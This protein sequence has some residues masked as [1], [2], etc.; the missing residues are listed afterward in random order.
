MRNSEIILILTVMSIFI[1]SSAQATLAECPACKGEQPDW[2]ESAT[3]FLEGRPINDTPSSLNGPQQ[4]RLLDAQIDA[5]KKASQ[6]S[7]LTNNGAVPHNLTLNAFDIDLKEI[8]ARPNPAESN[9]AVR[10]VTVFENISSNSTIRYKPPKTPNLNPLIVYADI[11][12]SAGLDVGRVSLKPSSA[13]EYS[14][15]WIAGVGAGTYGATIEASRPG[16][17]KKFNDALQITIRSSAN[18]TGNVHAIRKLG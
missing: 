11:K 5:K 4:A 18:T 9:N 16:E 17:S 6:T 2:T 1:S 12:N 3:A 8:Y 10:I 15:V 7:N 14:G 13:N